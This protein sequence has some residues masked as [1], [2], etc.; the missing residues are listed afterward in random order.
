MKIALAQINTTVGDFEGNVAKILQYA[1]MA[2]DRKAD[3]V[4]FHEMVGCGYPAGDLGGR[5]DFIERS[6]SELSRLS[7]LLPGIPALIGYVRAPPVPLGKRVSK[8]AALVYRG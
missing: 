4:V 5:R 1:R 7:H 2:A 8:A 6:E 3:L